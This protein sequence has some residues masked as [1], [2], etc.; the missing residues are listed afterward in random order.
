MSI[1]D[2][3]EKTEAQKAAEQIRENAKRLLQGEK[4]RCKAAFDQLW[5]G[6]TID[7]VR[8]IIEEI[9]HEDA[10]QSM[11]VHSK[12]QE[13]ITV[14]DP[15]Y[16]KLVPPYDYVIDENGITLSEKEVDEIVEEEVV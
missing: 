12:W 15:T 9:G 16:V 8:A 6:K 13:F 11:V 14:A 4:N 10:I 5:A 2:E 7:E 1:Y 3:V